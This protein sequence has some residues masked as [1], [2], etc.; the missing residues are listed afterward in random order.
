MFLG[1]LAI[2]AGAVLVVV[3]VASAIGTVVVPRGVP[4]RLTLVVFLAMRRIF[5]VPVRLTR[6]PQRA[7]HLLA[8]YA[9]LSLL[10]LMATWMV[11]IATGFTAIF[12]GLDVGPLTRSFEASGSSITTLGFVP[13][14][15]APQQSAA[16][17]E[18]GLGLLVLALL[19]TYL[20]SMY[21]A[22]QRRESLVTLASMQAG[23]PAS[24]IALLVRF[25]QIRGFQALEEKVWE[26]WTVGFVDIEESH[27]SLAA[28]PFFR[29]P[30]PDRNWVTAAGAVLDAA[31]LLA[32][33]VD[34]DRQP[35]AELCIRAGY[36]SL[37]RIADQLDLAY[38]ADPARGD[39]IMVTRE[40]W[41]QARLALAAVGAP[42]RGD[43]DEAWLDFA[44]WRVNYDAVL[45]GLAGVVGAPPAPWSADRVSAE[46]HHPRI[47][48]RRW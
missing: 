40:E 33:T 8:H 6:H 25:Q 4:V 18:A 24:G 1:G 9:P 13:L 14:R 22:F 30:Q 17:I 29:S 26:P 37:R 21:A 47:R 15:S 36:L 11:L 31:S 5:T 35:G 2:L 7:E 20:P 12:W 43:V 34:G 42:V 19:V 28:L 44:G 41:E 23:T 10:A 46:R 48:R 16:F 32:S 45:I 3:T 39:P 38:P 27:T